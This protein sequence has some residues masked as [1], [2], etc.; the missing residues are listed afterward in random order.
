M[1]REDSVVVV[2]GMTKSGIYNDVDPIVSCEA[3]R[4]HN[5]FN[6]TFSVNDSRIRVSWLIF[7]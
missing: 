7:F 2:Y 3:Q 4:L 6:R 1:I 5:G